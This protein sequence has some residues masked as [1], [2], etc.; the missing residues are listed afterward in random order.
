M[1]NKKVTVVASQEGVV[2]R[3]N[4][5]NPEFGHI[6]VSQTTMVM[7]NGFARK[8]SRTALI[9]GKLADLREMGLK[10]GEELE[11]KI[12]VKESLKPFNA[13]NPDSDLKVAGETGVPCTVSGQPIYRKSFY[14]TDDSTDVLIA[15]DNIDAIK[16]KQAEIAGL[17]G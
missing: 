10:D 7:E 6:R 4:P 15:H 3:P 14:V 12:I 16:A 2:A 5:N 9:N 8:V 13:E 11:G 1:K 17:E